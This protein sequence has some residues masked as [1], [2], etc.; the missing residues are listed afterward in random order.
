MGGDN[1][2]MK[3]K[4][5]IKEFGREKSW[6]ILFWAIAPSSLLKLNRRFGGTF[7]LHL[8]GQIS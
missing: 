7:R 3:M 1:E 2:K 8:Q 6:N 4:S 5:L